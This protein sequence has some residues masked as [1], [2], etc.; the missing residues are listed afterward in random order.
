M[1]PR[2]LHHVLS[3]ANKTQRRTKQESNDDLPPD[4]AD[5]SRAHIGDVVTTEPKADLDSALSQVV[6]IVAEE[7]GIDKADLGD[8]TEFALIG[9]DSLL[10]LLITSRLKED[11]NFD[12]GSGRSVFD[13][14]STL[15][16]LKAGYARNK[17]VSLETACES[18]ASR[19]GYAT[20]TPESD[21]SGI[22]PLEIVAV[23]NEA[24]PFQIPERAS[25]LEN[26]TESSSSS[27]TGPGPP[28]PTPPSR[29]YP[30]ASRSSASFVPTGGTHKP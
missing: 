8:D 19:E 24:S 18:P 25:I 3:S 22:T 27:P 30:P 26:Q 20:E 17:G 11:L 2:L 12:I 15:G 7:S 21:A 14:F 23:S 29:R 9:I 5:Y 10:S 16:Q 6:E 13:E 28:H 1:P 4:F